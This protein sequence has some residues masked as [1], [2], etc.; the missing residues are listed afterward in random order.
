MQA[1]AAGGVLAHDKF[2]GTQHVLSGSGPLE[3]SPVE[4]V[5][6]LDDMP[7]AQLMS[8]VLKEWGMPMYDASSD[9]TAD[10][11][12]LPSAAPPAPLLAPQRAPAPAP[13]RPAA[14]GGAVASMRCLDTA[15]GR[16]CT[17]CTPAPLDG[18]DG[19]F[20]SGRRAAFRRHCPDAR[21]RAAAALYELVGDQGKKNGEK[22]R[23][24]G[25]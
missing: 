21:A 4:A 6:A 9:T 18:E 25:G 12:E 17:E 15:H 5:F 7:F 3:A 11:R 8:S 23:A 2:M 16:G 19:A 20:V 24:A 13:Q 14:A 1:L 22:V 10:L